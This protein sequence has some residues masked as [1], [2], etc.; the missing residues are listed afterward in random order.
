MSDVDGA[1]SDA[2]DQLPTLLHSEPAQQELQPS[3]F[4]LATEHLR[5]FSEFSF[6]QDSCGQCFPLVNWGTFWGGQG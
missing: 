3:N 5:E 6:I 4:I 1:K 2:W